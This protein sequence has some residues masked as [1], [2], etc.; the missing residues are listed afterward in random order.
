[1]VWNIYQYISFFSHWHRYRAKANTPKFRRYGLI[2]DWYSRKIGYPWNLWRNLRDIWLKSKLKRWWRQASKHLAS[3]LSLNFKSY[4]HL[5]YHEVSKHLFLCLVSKWAYHNVMEIKIL[6]ILH[7]SKPIHGGI[8]GKYVFHVQ[9]H[10]LNYLVIWLGYAEL[11]F[12]H[13]T[14]FW[15]YMN[16]SFTFCIDEVVIIICM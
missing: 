4:T 12:D 2:S 3:S 8:V 9:A 15:M 13:R 11:C 10:N 5:S 1:M 7:W 16:L 6:H 14:S